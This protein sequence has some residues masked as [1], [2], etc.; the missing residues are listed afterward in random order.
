MS[1]RENLKIGFEIPY[2]RLQAV[3]LAHHKEAYPVRVG[4]PSRLSTR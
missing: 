2:H 4:V 1:I 3:F